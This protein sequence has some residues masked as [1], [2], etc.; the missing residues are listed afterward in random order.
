[1]AFGDI[2]PIETE[3]DT[4]AGDS[5]PA[6]T[7]TSAPLPTPVALDPTKASDVD[8]GQAPETAMAA[9]PRRQTW[10]YGAFV[11]ILVALGAGLILA[12]RRGD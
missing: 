11:L 10:S 7:V 8:D 4:P 2:C 3:E 9:R 6:A 5:A 1:M 12:K